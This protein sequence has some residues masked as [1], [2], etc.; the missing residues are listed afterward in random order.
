M[1]RAAHSIG[2]FGF[3]LNK[4]TLYRSKSGEHHSV[5]SQDIPRKGRLHRRSL[6]YA[7]LRSRWQRGRP[8]FQ[9]E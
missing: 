5:H 8:W 1:S 3:A 6:H 2:I 4:L 7:A 9:R